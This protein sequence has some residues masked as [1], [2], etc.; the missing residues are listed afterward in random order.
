MYGGWGVDTIKLPLE[1]DWDVEAGHCERCDNDCP[2]DGWLPRTG[3]AGFRIQENLLAF[4]NEENSI[5]G[6]SKSA[7]IRIILVCE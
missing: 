7:Y 6:G 1:C 5:T 2:F 4:G 3:V